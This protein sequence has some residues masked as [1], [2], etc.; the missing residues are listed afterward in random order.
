[1][2]SAGSARRGGAWTTLI[3]TVVVALVALVAPASAQ[4]PDEQPEA[5]PEAP[6]A[7]GATPAPSETAG[8]NPEL[9]ARLDDLEQQVRIE[10]RKRELA[11]EAAATKKDDAPTIGTDDKGFSLRSRD[12]A[13]VLRLRGL[14]QID[15]RFFAR[16]DAL[17]ASDT[18]L[19]R[20][21][22]PTLDGTVFSL[23]DFRFV[24]EFAGTVQIL[25]AYIDVHPRSWL[26]LR[27]G[28]LKTPVGL[29][30]LQSDAD[31]PIIERALDQNLSSQRDV[32][33]LLWGDVA[34]GIVQYTAGLVNGTADTASGDTDLDHA[35]DFVG[36]VFLQPFA[37]ESL[38][39]FGSLGVGLA[40]QTGNRKGRLPTGVSGLVI[41]SVTAQ[42]GLAGFKTAGQNTFFSYFA[43]AT[44][45]T[46]ATTTFTHDRTTHLNPQL[47]YYFDNV[48]LLA[49]YLYLWQGVQRGNS[50]TVLKHQAAHATLA[51]AIGGRE[52]F[53]GVTPTTGFG[54]TTGGWGALEIAARWSWLKVDPATFGNPA[55][56]G[57][58]VYADPLKSVRSA[59]SFAGGLAW[60][61]RRTA[62]LSLDV[63]QTR[64]SGGAGTAAV[65]ATPGVP[66]MPAVGADR[67]TEYVFIG[68]AQVNF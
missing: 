41:P 11:A 46:G 58:A 56:S 16:D 54:P 6:P 40:A 43:P 32:G 20:R 62:R 8:V 67:K 66:A 9:A 29:E 39:D 38:R 30:R 42:T 61:P 26:R 63:E 48:G 28:K 14:L 37:S 23:V 59:Q 18:F 27:A 31:L 57:A 47:Y 5:A 3:V 15:G 68:R 50:T 36:R 44:D 53:D 65:A 49:E 33:A 13:Y 24:P 1:V 25:D 52:G 4:T 7:E 55:V 64:F 17:E 35:K 60:I 10:A 34:G 19:V 12:A 22:R 2:S 51:Y 21:F 45:L